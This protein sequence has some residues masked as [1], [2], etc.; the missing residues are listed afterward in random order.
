MLAAIKSCYNRRV[1][2]AC[3]L[4]LIPASAK[5]CQV[6]SNGVK[7]CQHGQHKYSSGAGAGPTM[8]S[9]DLIHMRVSVCLMF[10]V[11]S[12][13]QRT[14]AKDT[15][16]ITYC[17]LEHCVCSCSPFTYVPSTYLPTS[18]PCLSNMTAAI[19]A[20]L[21]W[22]GQATMSSNVPT[23]HNPALGVCIRSFETATTK[24]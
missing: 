7:W 4:V 19:V 21:A 2:V 9:H 8:A 18:H 11:Y 16:C 12:H 1:V 14:I 6:V 3:D 20:G 10:I 23:V 24:L 13:G 5:W 15:S 17:S 22:P